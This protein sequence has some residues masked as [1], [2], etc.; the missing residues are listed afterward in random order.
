M[1]SWMDGDH[2][3]VHHHRKN[4]EKTGSPP[5]SGRWTRLPIDSEPAS[6]LHTKR[7]GLAGMIWQGVHVSLEED[8]CKI[9]NQFYLKRKIVLYLNKDGI[10]A[11]RPKKEE[12][13]VL[14]KYNSIVL[15]QLYQT[16]LTF[17]SHDQ[18][19]QQGVDKVYNWIQKQWFSKPRIPGSWDSPSNR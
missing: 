6:E 1:W 17:H 19:G 3:D 13:K 15:P 10:V 9:L 5:E 14:Y 4:G 8:S 16:E 7:S 12:D 2:A 18:I 11:W